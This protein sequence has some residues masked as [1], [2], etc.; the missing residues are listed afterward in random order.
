MSGPM[1]TNTY[2]DVWILPFK[3]QE[4]ND[5]PQLT[6]DLREAHL[7]LD[8]ESESGEY[9]WSEIVFRGVHAIAFTGHA[10]CTRDQV[11]AYDRLV[12]VRHSDWLAGLVGADAGQEHFRIYF[13]EFGCY[14]IAATTFEVRDRA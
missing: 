12:R 13:D 4:F 5:G 14:D 9:E 10:S 2:E 6:Q 1:P 11:R 7:R 3:S 8:H